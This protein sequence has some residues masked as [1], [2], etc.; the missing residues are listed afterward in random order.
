MPKIKQKIVMLVLNDFSHDS[1]VLREAKALIEADY[2]VFILALHDKSLTR[3]ETVEGIGVIRLPLKTRWLLEKTNVRFI[4]YLEFAIRALSRLQQIKPLF[5]HC[6]DLNTLPI[7]YLAKKLLRCYLIYDSHELES[8]KAGLDQ[9]AKWLRWATRHLEHFLIRQADHVITVGQGIADYL[10][11]QDNIKQPLVIRNIAE[12][13]INNQKSNVADHFGFGLDYKIMIYQ[14]GFQIWRGI[15]NLITSMK[16]LDKNTILVLIGDGPIRS[17]L[18]Q[19]TEKLEL[20]NRVFFKGWQAPE[21]LLNMTKQGDLGILCSENICLSYYLTLPSKFFEYISA[22][23]PVATSHF[24]EVTELI[25]RYH[26]GETFNPSNPR[27]MARAIKLIFKN[28]TRY[29]QLKNNVLQTQLTLNWQKEK[30]KLIN[31]YQQLEKHA[32]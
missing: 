29:Q 22:G 31:L 8:Q 1:R 25:Q 2:Q 28:P 13:Q 12:A 10:V 4:R 26:I 3:Q 18:K 15:E 32:S 20:K 23:L 21:K 19:L 14:G 16:F 6:H 24:P 30:Q 11:R 27:D 5:C 17:K 7:G 9:E